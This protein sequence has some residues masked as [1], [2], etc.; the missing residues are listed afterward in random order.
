MKNKHSVSLWG[1]IIYKDGTIIGQHGKRLRDG[2]IIAIKWENKDFRYVSHARFV[3]YAFNQDKFDF[4]DK[5]KVVAL[6][7][8]NK[9]YKLDNLQLKSNIE[10]VRGRR[11]LTDEQ[12]EEVKRLRHEDRRTYKDIAK[13]FGISDTMVAYLIKGYK[14]KYEM[15]SQE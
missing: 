10:Q 6:K 15:D 9:G 1:Y 5:S 11:K 7:N 4:N 2:D 12:V 14:T 13:R 3:Y 8:I